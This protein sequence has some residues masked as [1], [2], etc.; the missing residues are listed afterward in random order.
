MPF[1]ADSKVIVTRDAKGGTYYCVGQTGTEV[2]SS[3]VKCVC[4]GFS[5]PWAAECAFVVRSRLGLGLFVAYLLGQF[6][7][8]IG[9]ERAPSLDQENYRHA[10]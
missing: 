4:S 10:R 5:A 9:E 2:C 8:M 6:M 3:S 1:L 7:L